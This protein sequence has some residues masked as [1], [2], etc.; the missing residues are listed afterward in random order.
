MNHGS[1]N[2]IQK[3][4]TSV[5]SGTHQTHHILKKQN[6]QSIKSFCLQN[7]IFNQHVYQK[8]LERLQ[9]SYSRVINNWE[10]LVLHHDSAPYHRALS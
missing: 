3:Q 10:Y 9:Q 1:L 5:R 4:N 7:I 2:T 8:N 6:A